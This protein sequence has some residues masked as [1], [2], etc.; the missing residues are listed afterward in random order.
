MSEQRRKREDRKTV[1]LRACLDILRKC[2]Q[3]RFVVSPM[4]VTTFYDGTDCDG[5]C[6]M[7]DIETELEIPL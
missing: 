5:F 3:S 4:E 7:E 1:L 6:L 2:D